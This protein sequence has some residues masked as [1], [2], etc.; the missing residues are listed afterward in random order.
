MKFEKSPKYK[1][2]NNELNKL[3]GKNLLD[4]LL[5]ENLL[6]IN[7]F[8]SNE[9]EEKFKTIDDFKT[10]FDYLK[11][12]HCIYSFNSSKIQSELEDGLL[13]CV[14]FDDAKLSIYETLQEYELIL[15]KQDY[16]KYLEN[17]LKTLNV[18]SLKH[19]KFTSTEYVEELETKLL[20]CDLQIKKIDYNLLINFYFQNNRSFSIIQNYLKPKSNNSVSSEIPTII[21]ELI[22]EYSFYLLYKIIF[23]KLSNKRFVKTIKAEPDI[24]LIK[25]APIDNLSTYDQ[26]YIMDQLGMLLVF[27]EDGRTKT[28]HYQLL[29]K[30]LGKSSE[31]I[32]KYLKKLEDKNPSE[33]RRNSNIKL[34][35][36]IKHG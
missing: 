32:R 11:S 15:D 14:K 22:K 26:L 13:K 10:P 31:N 27:E 35:K 17:S 6:V 1:V 9:D 34:D 20:K 16:I 29:S 28:H 5:E 7:R 21:D 19:F 25:Q 3:R 36:F 23:E 18:K 12:T 2:Y 8:N 4:F 33:D 24:N 30:I